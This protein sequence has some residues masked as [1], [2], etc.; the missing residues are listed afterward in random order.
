MKSEEKNFLYLS[1]VT[2]ID[3]LTLYMMTSPP[4][5]LEEYAVLQRILVRLMSEETVA[6]LDKEALDAFAKGAYIRAAALVAAKDQETVQADPATLMAG[7]HYQIYTVVLSLLRAKETPEEYRL[8]LTAAM[9][10]NHTLHESVGPTLSAMVQLA[11]EHAP[12][13]G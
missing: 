6:T 5:A 1:T 2:A 11:M 8:H 4:P 9:V 13:Q 7:I 3:Q 12:Q 10:A